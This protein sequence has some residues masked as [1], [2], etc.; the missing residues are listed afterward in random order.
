MLIPMPVLSPIEKKMPK[1][2]LKKRLSLLMTECHHGLGLSMPPQMT[3]VENLLS[4]MDQLIELVQDLDQEHINDYLFPNLEK[5]ALDHLKF[6]RK[7]LQEVLIQCHQIKSSLSSLQ[8]KEE[9]ATSMTLPE[10]QK[11][12]TTLECLCPKCNKD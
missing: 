6:Q 12:C 8:P 4:Q 10:K 2:S 3:E 5:S 11:D 9:K 7:S 1:I